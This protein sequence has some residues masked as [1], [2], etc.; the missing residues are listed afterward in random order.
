MKMIKWKQKIFKQKRLEYLKNIIKKNSKLLRVIIIL[1]PPGTNLLSVKSARKNPTKIS[2]GKICQE[3]SDRH[4]CQ[5]NPLEINFNPTI[6]E[7]CVGY[8]YPSEIL[9]NR[10]HI[11][12]PKAN[13]VVVRNWYGCL[14]VVLKSPIK[15]KKNLSSNWVTN[16]K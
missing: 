6:N 4:F 12:T 7:I 13:I 3:K 1:N 8:L 14:C 15:T 9:I 5:K 11:S 2:V 10:H 16:P